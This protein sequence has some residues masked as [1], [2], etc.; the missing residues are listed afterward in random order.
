MSAYAQ[1]HGVDGL[2]GLDLRTRRWHEDLSGY[3]PVPL[4]P[5]GGL[6]SLLPNEAGNNLL[7]T[8][9]H[10]PETW[11][12]LGEPHATLRFL[13]QGSEGT[14]RLTAR[15]L[16]SPHR[17]AQAQR[18]AVIANGSL[19]ATWTLSATPAEHQVLLPP[20]DAARDPVEF[21][22]VAEDPA[23]PQDQN[24][25]VDSTILGLGLIAVGLD[26]P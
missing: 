16:A 18:V 4:V 21:T 12:R 20:P 1:A 23:R 2:C 17:P 14:L 15:A 11:G 7:Q 26:W 9:W 13:P 25:A 24:G 22:F 10:A 19:A 3:Q 8:G 5:T 6:L